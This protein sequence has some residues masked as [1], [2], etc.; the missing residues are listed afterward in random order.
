MYDMSLKLITM[1]RHLGCLEEY[2]EY[3]NLVLSDV[4][5][6]DI[7]MLMKPAVCEGEYVPIYSS[8]DDVAV[9]GC[10]GDILKEWMEENGVTVYS[11]CK[12]AALAFCLDG[13]VI[14]A[15]NNL[16]GN[17]LEVGMWIFSDSEGAKEFA[18]HMGLV[19][20]NMYDL[21]VK[22]IR[23]S[24]PD[25]VLAL[26]ELSRDEAVFPKNSRMFRIMHKSDSD[27][28]GGNIV[29]FRTGMKQEK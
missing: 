14:S 11:D 22:T 13:T 6:D 16:D 20:D 3:K 10:M 15:F 4:N 23:K 29:P 26:Q 1:M 21:A 12:L 18:R 19:Y 8:A 2:G 9:A 7:P 5:L 24:N 25:A 17:P 28:V 27:I